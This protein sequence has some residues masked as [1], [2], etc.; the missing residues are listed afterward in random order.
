[1]NRRAWVRKS[2]VRSSTLRIDATLP[3][4]VVV[5][6]LSITGF[7]YSSEEPV[8]AGEL[9]SVGLAGSGQ[10]D[11]RVI[12]R[13]G[14]RHGAR[15]TKALAQ[16]TIDAAFTNDQAGITATIAREPNMLQATACLESLTQEDALGQPT[17]RI[18]PYI[19]FI[20]AMLAG[21]LIWK[22]LAMLLHVYLTNTG[23]R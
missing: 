20:L 4:D 1:M 2:I 3:M 19:S 7:R 16:S 12:W 23:L 5:E 8:A 11:A 13:D 21:G 18:A 22:I 10:A 15:F 14:A 9:V 6:D 17:W